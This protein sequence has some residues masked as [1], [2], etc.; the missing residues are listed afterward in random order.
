MLRQFELLSTDVENIE[1]LFEDYYIK[2][3][4][5]YLLFVNSLLKQKHVM[6]CR[7][8]KHAALK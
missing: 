6:S 1:T 4:V 3:L 8:E 2:G 7:M 5:V